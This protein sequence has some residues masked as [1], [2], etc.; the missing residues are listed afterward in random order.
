MDYLSN[1][2][3]LEVND[4]NVTQQH[5]LILTNTSKQI[6]PGPHDLPPGSRLG[7]RQLQLPCVEC[8]PIVGCC[9]VD[10]VTW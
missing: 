10:M 8:M 3:Q 5:P 9:A 7:C 2:M 6:F 1:Y 4:L